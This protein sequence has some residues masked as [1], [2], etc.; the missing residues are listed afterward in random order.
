MF[1]VLILWDTALGKAFLRPGQSIIS[2][3]WQSSTN[4]SGAAVTS[5]RYTVPQTSFF[6]IPSHAWTLWTPSPFMSSHLFLVVTASKSGG[7]LIHLLE[8]FKLKSV[9]A[10]KS[11]SCSAV[12]WSPCS[13]TCSGISKN[14]MTTLWNLPN[15]PSSSS[16]MIVGVSTAGKEERSSM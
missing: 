2:S 15:I 3:F 5:F 10:S 11:N 9:R 16:S 14:P 12:R 1:F 6:A 8:L 7:L 13:T 4:V